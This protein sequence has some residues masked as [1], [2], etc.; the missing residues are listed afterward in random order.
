V[1]KLKVPALKKSKRKRKFQDSDDDSEEEDEG[2][3]EEDKAAAQMKPFLQILNLD[4]GEECGPLERPP[5]GGKRQE[6][7]ALALYTHAHDS[8]NTVLVKAEECTIV[9]VATAEE[10]KVLLFSNV[11]WRRFER[12]VMAQFGMKSWRLGFLASVLYH[13]R[14]TLPPVTHPPTELSCCV[15]HSW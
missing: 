12:A 11:N 3:S 2:E 9:P 1:E 7:F 4:T 14:P 8:E 5:R 15:L 13:V 6:S 10:A